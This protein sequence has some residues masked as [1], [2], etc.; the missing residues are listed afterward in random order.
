MEFA[1]ER[2][3]R[4]H[5]IE[6][7][8]PD[9]S[10]ATKRA[11]IASA[12]GGSYYKA[13]R[14]AS[15]STVGGFNHGVTAG[16]PV[17]INSIVDGSTMSL[18]GAT[19]TPGVPPNVRMP[20]DGGDNFS[21]APRSN[22]PINV[23]VM[24]RPLNMPNV[25]L[26]TPKFTVGDTVWVT[27]PNRDME[28]HAAGARTMGTLV[29]MFTTAQVRA[30]E[31]NHRHYVGTTVTQA[32]AGVK[33]KP[34]GTLALLQK[35]GSEV[36]AGTPAASLV[37][38]PGV[39]DRYLLAG[40]VA[41]TFLSDR[42]T[43]MVTLAVGGP[44][45]VNNIWGDVRVGMDLF[46]RDLIVEEETGSGT[47]AAKLLEARTN[48]IKTVVPWPTQTVLVEYYRYLD[49]EVDNHGYYGRVMAAT[50]TGVDVR[51]IGP[52]MF[53][54]TTT[55]PSEGGRYGQNI[56][57]FGQVLDVYPTASSTG[58]HVPGPFSGTGQD[59]L[60]TLDALTDPRAT[61]THYGKILVNVAPGCG[62]DVYE[63]A[64]SLEGLLIR[65]DVDDF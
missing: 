60:L 47:L 42:S 58:E 15:R 51:H 59:E 5:A 35:D 62:M 46:F 28:A 61:T 25:G 37:E 49:E 30:M 13:V 41:A 52:R 22:Q 64:L 4:L 20:A 7:G 33:R 34:D 6:H 17:S 44:I 56:R 14:A 53:V 43:P 65:D 9:D 40:V 19:S 3:K 55:P 39:F 8:T 54:D 36:A 31:A 10:P 63:A 1:Y 45:L 27:H 24:V 18:L 26:V 29:T 50:T 23:S 2:M 12:P 16:T 38:R 57:I 32:E 21:G 11:R 48:A